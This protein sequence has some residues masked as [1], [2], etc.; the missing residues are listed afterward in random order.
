[1]DI[2]EYKGA[3]V[4]GNPVNLVTTANAAGTTPSIGPFTVTGTSVVVSFVAPVGN[5]SAGDAGSNYRGSNPIGCGYEDRFVGPGLNTMSF[6]IDAGPSL[7]FAVAFNEESA[8]A[9]V[10]GADF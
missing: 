5:V 6:T 7:I 4:N 1:M 10:F 3:A 9:L 8:N 2:A